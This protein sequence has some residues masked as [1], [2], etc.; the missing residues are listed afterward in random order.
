M[1]RT[2]LTRPRATCCTFLTSVYK[3]FT[4]LPKKQEGEQKKDGKV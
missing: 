2:L 1:Y 3:P 4:F